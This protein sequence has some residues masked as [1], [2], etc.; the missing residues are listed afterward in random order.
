MRPNPAFVA[1]DV[2]GELGVGEALV[3]ALDAKGRPEMVER[4]WMLPPA[5]RIGPVTDAERAALI[6]T[7][8]VAG[9]YDQ[10][11][12]RESAFEVLRER[13]SQA[14]QAQADAKPAG[15]GK[16]GGAAAPAPAPQS[17][18]FGGLFGDALGGLLGGSGR[19]DSVLETAAKSM[20]RTVGTQL[21]R[22]IT[23]GVL[24]SMRK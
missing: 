12:D 8:V 24:G 4:V 15:R 21:G 1:E 20:M 11:V 23:R 14:A 22:A 3:S 13:A 7:S 5:S 6:K 19:K 9:V 2:I 10:V 17:G 18:G 16:A